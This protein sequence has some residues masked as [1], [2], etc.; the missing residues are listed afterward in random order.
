MVPR[1]PSTTLVKNP[2]LIPARILDLLDGQFI[3]DVLLRNEGDASVVAFE[4]GA[5]V[6]LDGEVADL[7]EF[8]EIP[9]LGTQRGLPRLAV[10]NKKGAGV[11]VSEDMER[12]G[13]VAAITRQITALTNSMIRARYIAMRT[14][15][16][17][18]AIP[19][20]AAS[21]AW[22]T[23]SGRPRKDLAGRAGGRQLRR[24]H[25]QPTTPTATRRTRSSCPAASPRC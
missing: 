20:I 8:E 12:E 22:D 10:A 16:T 21:A 25:R 11:R 24:R 5:S 4:E 14:L 18:P 23:A 2:L 7:V 13:N 6:F 3:D 9:V 17:N 19:T 15:L 1:S